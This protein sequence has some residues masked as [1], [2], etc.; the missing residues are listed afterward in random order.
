MPS[1]RGADLPEVR[2]RYLRPPGRI[3]VF[4]QTLVHEDAAVKVTFARGL[5]REDPLRI[6][7]RIA[8]EE[9]SD[10]VWFTF[11][12]AWHDIGRFHRAD[13]SL[14]GIYANVIS[15]CRFGPGGI[16]ETT[17]LFL[18][19]WI[20]AAE[21]HEDSG[22]ADAAILLDEEELEEAE[23]EEWVDR[24]TA[25]RARAEA[26]RLLEAAAAGRWPPAVVHEWTR[27]RALARLSAASSE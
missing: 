10:A 2:I 25:R 21:G 15:P 5:E 19:L 23:R 20:P 13:G 27:E 18:D 16:W 4:V 11:P 9:G 8:L 3:D 1:P 6:G 17:D 22:P 7:G 24:A 12:E 14:T 26:G